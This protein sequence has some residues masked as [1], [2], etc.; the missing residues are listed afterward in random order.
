MTSQYTPIDLSQLPPPD[1]IE[2][3]DFEVILQNNIDTY[4]QQYPEF[5][6]TLESEP[7]IKL[8]ELFSYKELY[9]RQ[10]VNDAARSVMLA[11]AGGNDLD[12]IAANYGVERQLIDEANPD[13]YPPIPATFETD[14]RLRK[15]TQLAPETW[16]TA[17][18]EGAYVARTLSAD[19]TVKDVTVLNPIPGRV[20]VTVLSTEGNGQANGELIAKVHEALSASTVRPLTDEVIV[21]SAKIIDYTV[22]ATLHIGKGPGHDIVLSTARVQLQEYVTQQHHLHSTVSLSGIYAALHVEGVAKVTLSSPRSDILTS[23]EQAPYCVDIR[24]NIANDNTITP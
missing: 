15:R 18:S 4:K 9:L 8:I 24:L 13:A 2:T 14:A 11:Y 23:P 12:H 1:V 16:T 3:L 6:A 22:E 10:R 21:Q 17:G 5:S 7:V 20:L 19:N